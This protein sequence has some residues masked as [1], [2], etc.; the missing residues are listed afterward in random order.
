M[1]NQGPG[2]AGQAG[3]GG[4][5]GK[6]DG[7]AFDPALLNANA[8]V[9]DF[10]VSSNPSTGSSSALPPAIAAA[11]SSNQSSS[12]LNPAQLQQL[13]EFHRKQ[14]L[15]RSAIQANPPSASPSPA[16]S[17]LVPPLPDHIRQH[18]APLSKVEKDAFFKQWLPTEEG[19][20]FS[21][22]MQQ[23]NMPLQQQ[24]QGASTSQAPQSSPAAS[25]NS[26]PTSTIP[27]IRPGSSSAN[28]NSTN[29]GPSSGVSTP[30]R[31]ESYASVAANIP[32]TQAF[33]PAS[34][35]SIPNQNQNQN[36]TPQSQAST[37]RPPNAPIHPQLNRGPTTGV[38]NSNSNSTSQW[39]QQ[40][41]YR[42]NNDYMRPQPTPAPPRRKEEGMRGT[43]RSERESR[44]IVA[45]YRR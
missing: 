30:E 36:Q 4:Q 12:S 37:P 26:S 31:R 5:G 10:N 41:P 28:L 35:R 3:M 1:S 16:Q 32:V 18:I 2:A 33:N 8:A 21:R 6:T 43:M 27:P 14:Q 45:M 24:R 34:Y 17:Q 42:P 29:I 44:L 40:T 22:L 15:Q 23:R 11:L 7:V 19:Q 39:V 13:T 9:A 20:R 25:S 38:F